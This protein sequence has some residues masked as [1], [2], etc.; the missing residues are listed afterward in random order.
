MAGR[1]PEAIGRLVSNGFFL[2]GKA[3]RRLLHEAL[4]EAAGS[5]YEV[6]FDLTSCYFDR[7]SGVY[8]EFYF[9]SV[10]L[11]DVPLIR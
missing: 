5:E 7:S 6:S 9:T 1:R 3:N 2:E 10:F 4:G 8:E 11:R